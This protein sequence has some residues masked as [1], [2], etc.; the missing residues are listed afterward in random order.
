MGSGQTYSGAV[1]YGN[2]RYRWPRSR[3]HI[4]NGSAA[5]SSRGTT[6]ADSIFKRSVNNAYASSRSIDITRAGG[7]YV[8]G[9]LTVGGY[10][11]FSQYSPD[12]CSTFRKSE[13]YHNGE[14]Y[15][16]WQLTAALQAEIGYDYMKSY[17][18]S[19]AKQ[20]QFALGVDYF[21]SKRTDVYGVASGQSGAGAAPTMIGSNNVDSGS[22]KQAQ[23]V[24]GMHHRF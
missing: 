4:D 20:N 11:S 13:K 23:V 8:H 2:A 24:V 1:S 6:S 19:S 14:V 15:V 17:G 7:N 5:L 18:D 21:L 9:D 22:N 16:L 10:Y 12:A 3:L